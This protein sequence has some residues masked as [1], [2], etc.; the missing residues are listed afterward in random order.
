MLEKQGATRLKRAEFAKRTGCNLETVRY[1]EKIG[2]MPAPPRSGAGYRLYG[3]AHVRR[4]R[5]ILRARELG[6]SIED[7]KGLLDLVDGGHHTC[8]QVKERTENHLTGVRAKIADLKRIE[9]VLSATALKCSGR[10][11]PECPVLDALVGVCA[12]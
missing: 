5:F 8:A 10:K 2:L 1:Y 9:K 6:F 3:E 12:K 4:L 7:I 11:V